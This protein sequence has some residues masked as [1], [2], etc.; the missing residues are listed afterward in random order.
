MSSTPKDR[1][2]VCFVTNELYPLGPGGIGRM[3]YNFAKHNEAMG[4]PA[5]LHFLV[6]PELMQARPDAASVLDAAF[7]DIAEIHVCPDLEQVPE[8]VAQ[9]FARAATHPWTLEQH[10]AQSY[11]FYVGL[12]EAERRRGAPFDFIEFPDFGGWGLASVEAKRAGLAFEHTRICARI[13]STQ[14]ILYRVERFSHHP[15]NWLGILFDAERHLLAH[16]DLIAGHDQAVMR[17]NEQHYGLAERWEGRT[18]AEFPPILSGTGDMSAKDEGVDDNLDSPDPDF[19]FSSRLQQ[20]KRPD[21]FVRAAVAFLEKHP[22]YEGKFRLVSYGWDDRYIAALEDLVPLDLKDRIPFVLNTSSA[23]RDAYLSRSTVVVPSDYESLCLFAFEAA[24]MG[25]KVILNGKCPP[26]GNVERWRDGENCLLFDGSV[27]ALVAVMERSK[28]WTPKGAVETKADPPYWLRK[29]F[30]VP[31]VPAR[32]DARVGG[33][34]VV[35]Y[36]FETV[37]EFEQHFSAVVHLEAA[38]DTAGGRDEIRFLLPRALFRP[39]GP[40]VRRIKERGWIAELTSG[41]SESPETLCNRLKALE[42]EVLFLYPCGYEVWP[43][44]IESGRIALKRDSSIGLFGGHIELVDPNTARS[45][46]VRA[47]GGEM[48]SSALLSSRIAPPLTFVRRK[49]LDR[50]PFDARAGNMWFEVFVRECAFRGERIAIAPV[51]A[52]SLDALHANAQETSKKISGGLM[53][54]IGLRAGFS[55]RLLAI[56]P[57]EPPEGSAPRPYVIAGEGLR[58][59]SR[60]H[61]KGALREWEPVAYREDLGGVLIH[62][63]L[64]QITIGELRGP[65]RRIGR[66]VVEVWNAHTD[67]SGAEVAIA[68]A[69]GDADG[70]KILEGLAQGKEDRQLAVS[71]WHLVEPECRVRIELPVFG[72]SA[73][74]DRLLLATRVPPGGQETNC[75]LVFHRVEA[76]FNENLL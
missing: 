32:S 57:V 35:C 49:V 46:Y 24:Q 44:F 45:D 52:G 48:P 7:D 74:L 55:S 4:M 15:S 12:R 10:V 67:N 72:A 18:I 39:Q 17:F 34:T 23:Q 59:V 60:I 16:A 36:G 42:N 20:F 51:I 31:R 22:S 62:P 1:P 68:L 66:V 43:D 5:D 33:I 75:H 27:E 58:V 19:I 2:V 70:K 11:Q 64:G 26:F 47:Y 21:V 73:G 65:P 3:L 50:V 40:E 14:G 9:L 25:R 41:V 54:S 8:A 6:P 56:D 69:S 28:D 37:A 53:D 13:H 76:W 29:D 38:L 71:A 61:P 30:E 63:L